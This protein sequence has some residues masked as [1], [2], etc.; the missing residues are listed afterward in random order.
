MDFTP[1]L[2]RLDIQTKYYGV[3]KLRLN[4]AQQQYVYSLKESMMAG[5]PPRFIVLKARQ[6]GISTVTEAIIFNWAFIF[7]RS[8][9]LVIAHE[10]DSSEHLL[11]MTNLYWESSIY[12]KMYKPLYKSRK[13]LAWDNMSAIR[14]TTAKNKNA[15]RSKTIQALHAS[16]VAFWDDPS[17]VMLGLRQ[18]IPSAPN[19]FICLESTANGVGDYFW[20]TWNAATSG[21]VEYVPLFFPWWKHPEYTAGFIGIESSFLGALDPEERV[22]RAMGVEDDRLVWRR[23]AIRNLAEGDLQKFHQEYPAT[24][25]EAFVST[26]FNVFPV[27]HLKACYKPEDGTKGRLVREGVRSARFVFDD[28]GPLTI[29]RSPHPDP[30]WGSYF[31]AGDPTHTTTHDFACIQV[32]NRRTYE[33]VAVWRGRIDPGSFAE[34][35]AKLGTYYNMGQVVSE[36][37][38]PGYM[39]IG[40]L[41]GL[42]Y[43]FI[44][45]NRF[46][47]KDPGKIQDSY[48]FD[49]S[50]KK[51]EWAVNN[52]LKLV[53]DHDV[54]I[55][56]KTTHNEMVNYITLPGGGYGPAQG[57]GRGHD[58]TVMALAIAC[59]CN[60]SEGNLPPLG[61]DDP[62]SAILNPVPT[63]ETPLWDDNANL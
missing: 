34:E 35:I 43:P 49:T 32:I 19:T 60:A 50:V 55:H 10:M 7:P 29:F 16:E 3:Q 1:L 25:E 26:G 53:V 28:E 24:P 23:W 17:T 52:L 45:K 27:N 4:W 33:Q 42:D 37:T 48:G 57:E 59:I 12:A 22:L 44:W 18:T 13:Y 51:K 31:I 56:D 61:R 8:Q 6:I 47:D 54:T 46:A 21:D 62:L 20:E 41:I 2:E 39:T 58:D 9:G 11:S 38:G 63:Q 5:K 40:R 14:I 36:S 30:D 15:G